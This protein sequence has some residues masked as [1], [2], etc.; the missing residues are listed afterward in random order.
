MEVATSLLYMEASLEDGEFDQPDQQPRLQRLAERIQAVGQGQ[1]AQPLETWMEDLYR[2]V[3][4][5]HTIG[6]VVQEL[7]STLSEAEERIDQFFRDPQDRTPLASVPAILQSMRGVLAVLG[8]DLAAQASV[9]MRDDVDHLLLDSTDLDDAAQRGVFDRLASNL[10]ALGFLIDMMGVQ[11]QLAKSLFKLDPDTGVLSPVMGRE[12][13]ALPLTDDPVEAVA[14]H[15]QQVQQEAQAAAGEVAQTLERSDVP[16]SEVSDQLDRLAEMPHVQEQRELA[17]NLAAAQAA[18]VTAQ[19]SDDL[20][21][22]AAAREQ[23]ANVLSGL[24]RAEEPE[25]EAPAPSPAPLLAPVAAAAPAETG[26]EE[27]DEMREIF[28]EE[29]REVIETARASLDHLVH[30]PDDFGVPD[31]GSPRLPHAQG[32]LA[33]GGFDPVW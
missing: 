19:S 31:V 13:R 22:V 1:P 7:R 6:S 2:R 32:Q 16:L 18:L 21:S 5:R 20:E 30:Q 33:H 27:D 8:L 14:Q 25:V 11:P 10:G 23:V 26:L 12:K 17:D 24:T 28:L 29:A 9:R 15:V 4:D 3:S